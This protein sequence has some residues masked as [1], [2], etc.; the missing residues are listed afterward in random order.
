[1]KTLKDLFEAF[2]KGSDF[3]RMTAKQG[4]WF[5]N[6]A[7]K[8]GAIDE[9]FGDCWYILVDGKKYRVG[10]TYIPMGC[11]GGGVGRK[12]ESGNYNVEPA[13]FWAAK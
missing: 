4:R 11:Y 13:N 7:K 9:T 3:F 8:E 10:K 6:I 12:K 2:G 1:M 5:L